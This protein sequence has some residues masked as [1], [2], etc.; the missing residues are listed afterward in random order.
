MGGVLRADIGFAALL[1]AVPLADSVKVDLAVRMR[2]A[3]RHYHGVGH[4]ALL[5]RR[6]CEL[7]AR[8]GYQD[9]DST[10]LIACAIAF[11]DAVY[12][13]AARDN[14]ERSAQIWLAASA[15]AATPEPTRQW[16]AETIRAS[17]SHLAYRP[18]GEDRLER[19]RLWFLDLDLSP[20]GE[21][22]AVFDHNTVLLRRECPHLDEATWQSRRIGFLAHL[23]SAP[24]LYRSPVFQ[25]LFERPAR[26]NI[27]RELARCRGLAEG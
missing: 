23:G 9:G 12:E 19:L 15:A 5:W 8:A 7:A 24:V 2:A 3:G 27:A 13:P 25:D 4:L 6:H 17:A 26:R 21:R 16:V 18:A 20:L 1:A 11:H 14:E 10:T 22:P